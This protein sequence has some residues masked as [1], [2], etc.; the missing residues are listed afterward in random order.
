M[1]AWCLAWDVM[2]NVLAEADGALKQDLN[3][4]RSCLC[5]IA[6]NPANH[7]RLVHSL[8]ETCYHCLARL[9]RDQLKA[10]R[11]PHPPTV[12]RAVP[13]SAICHL[14]SAIPQPPTGP[15]AVLGSQP[16]L[17]KSATPLPHSAE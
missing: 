14:P 5:A 11:A 4:E 1:N 8:Q 13:G 15:R 17:S 6:V 7:A 9:S 12:P 10:L 16:K 2:S 3:L